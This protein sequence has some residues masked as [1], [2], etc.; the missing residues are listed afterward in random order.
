MIFSSSTQL[1]IAGANGSIRQVAI[2]HKPV[3]WRD[4]CPLYKITHVNVRSYD[5]PVVWGKLAYEA[6]GLE[7]NTSFL[8]KPVASQPPL[9]VICV[10]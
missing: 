7:A 10:H 4:A 5:R 9:L 2:R 1:K 6:K 8:A 3:V